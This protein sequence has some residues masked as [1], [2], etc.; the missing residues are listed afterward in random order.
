MLTAKLNYNE[1]ISLVQP[2]TRESLEKL[3]SEGKFYCPVCK[4]SLILKLG[5]LRHWHFA[6]ERDNTCYIE[7]EPETKYHL[8]G[9]LQLYHWLQAQGLDVWLE[10]YLKEIKQRPD[11]LVRR[12]KHRYAIEFQCSNISIDLLTKRTNSFINHG[13][14]PIWVLGANRLVRKSDSTV[15]LRTLEWLTTRTLTKTYETPSILLY[16]SEQKSFIFLT[17]FFS[18]SSM[19]ASATFTVFPQHQISFD[20]LLNDSLISKKCLSKEKILTVKRHWRY[21]CPPFPSKTEKHMSQLYFQEQH[22]PTLFPCEAGWPT[23]YH[24]YLQTSPHLWQSWILL[25]FLH[26][27]P[28]SQPFSYQLLEHAFLPMLEYGLFKER[29]F[30]QLKGNVSFALKGYLSFLQK[31]DIIQIESKSHIIKKREVEL[32]QHIEDAIRGDQ[33][34]YEKYWGKR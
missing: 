11:L 26:K 10:P 21:S 20:N 18:T 8:E 16:C 34:V 15:A 17:D 24:Y 28:I 14:T 25:K 5:K 3:R 32:P 12:G 2:Y 4:A 29:T 33:R 7:T 1:E 27:R 31:I 30:L 22:Y 19:K 9:K 6:H 23:P 13:I